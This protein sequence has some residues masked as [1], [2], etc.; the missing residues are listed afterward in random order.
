MQYTEKAGVLASWL[1]HCDGYAK[2]YYS[3]RYNR[4]GQVHNLK[5]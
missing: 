2:P 1:L 3:E 4:D 5:N